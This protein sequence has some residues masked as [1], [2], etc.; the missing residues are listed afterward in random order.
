MMYAPDTVSE[1][2]VAAMMVLAIAGAITDVRNY[3]IPNSIN[4]LIAGLF[5]VYV[6]FSETGVD[7]S[8]ALLIAGAVFAAAAILFSLGFIGGGDAKMLTV[9]ALWAGPA[10]MADFIFTTTLV[11]GVLAVLMMTSARH[12][13]ALAAESLGQ[14]RLSAVFQGDVLPYGVAIAA[15]GVVV[16]LKLIA[17]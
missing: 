11:G 2:M 17:A 4:L 7:W 9:L 12:A 15:G 3:R 1:Y 6:F 14:H 13:L 10:H 5:P 8:F 16:G